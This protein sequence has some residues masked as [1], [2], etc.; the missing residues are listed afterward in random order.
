[1]PLLSSGKT[2]REA[3]GAA[4]PGNCFGIR[5]QFFEFQ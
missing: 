3:D 4:N 2:E 5:V 1:M